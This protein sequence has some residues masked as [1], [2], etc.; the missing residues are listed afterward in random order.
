M[1]RTQTVAAPFA[2]LATGLLFAAYTGVEFVQPLEPAYSLLSLSIAILAVLVLGAVTFSRRS[3][4]LR[5]A[6]LSRRG[7][8]LL[9]AATLLMLPIL[10][11]ST[12]FVGWHWTAA[13]VYAPVSG[14]AQELFFRACVLALLES[15]V[16]DNATIALFAHSLAFVAWHMRTFTLLP[17]VPVGLLVAM[18]IFLAGLAWGRQV[19]RDGTVVW[20]MAQHSLF[21]VA[22]SMFV[23]T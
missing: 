3:L 11:S 23:W 16:P 12:G 18:V 10:A 1:G 15:M 22:M 17:S 19:Q 20:S 5:F 4:R 2:I 13:L 6:P 9:A 21:L 14:I 8:A 7:A